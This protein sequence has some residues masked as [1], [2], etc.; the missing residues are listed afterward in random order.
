MTNVCIPPRRGGALER[1]PF[2]AGLIVPWRLLPRA[3]ALGYFRPPLRGEHQP[4]EP[5][6]PPA[7]PRG[8]PAGQ[9]LRPRT[10]PAATARPP[11]ASPPPGTGPAPLTDRCRRPARRG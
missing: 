2:G 6:T 4:R 1:R 10:R 9:S 8:P 7:A 3:A 5:P 11:P